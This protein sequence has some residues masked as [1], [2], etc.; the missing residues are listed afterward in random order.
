MVKHEIK[1]EISKPVELKNLIEKAYFEEGDRGK[2]LG[3]KNFLKITK[4]DDVNY[5]IFKDLNGTT[6]KVTNSEIIDGTMRFM[7]EES[8][9]DINLYPISIYAIEE[10]SKYIFY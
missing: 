8:E 6:V 3:K 9:E 1:V 4:E 2:V 5:T 10:N 7:V